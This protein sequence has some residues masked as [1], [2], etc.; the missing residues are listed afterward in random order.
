MKLLFITHCHGNYGASR[1]LQ[2]LL[3]KYDRHEI[4]LALPKNSLKSS[5]KDEI[6]SFYGPNVSEIKYFHLP[7]K[8]CYMGAP[9]GMKFKTLNI[10]RNIFSLFDRKK[11]Y[12]FIKARGFD[13]IHLN[14]PVL[15]PLIRPDIPFIVHM[16]DVMMMEQSAAVKKVLQAKGII[17]IDP[18]TM[19]PFKGLELRNSVILNNPFDM[20][21]LEKG[22]DENIILREYGIF[23]DRIIFSCIGRIKESKGVKFVVESFLKN[24]NDKSV[25]LIFGEGDQGSDYESGCREIAS[26]DKRI[27][28]MGEES[29]IAKVYRISDYT[30]RGDPWHLIGRTVF[31]GLYS[32]CDVIMPGDDTDLDKNQDL[33]EFSDKVHLYSARN[34]KEL[35]EKISSLSSKVKKR[36][37]RS[38]TDE[39]VE[40]FDKFVQKAI[41]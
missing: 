4:V 18:G 17:F 6:R 37:F 27:R 12:S 11:I 34:V 41:I 5:T 25:L 1:S 36:V 38:N 29:D 8:Y 2:S 22:Y 24:T 31:E 40:K 21:A 14:A 20:T 13:A 16:R 23:Q 7:F 35:A 19:E 3:L 30:I 10:L 9:E 26:K 39:Y 28:F 15:Y 33:K 32:G